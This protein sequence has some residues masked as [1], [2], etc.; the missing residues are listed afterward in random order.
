MGLTQQRIE[1]TS[2]PAVVFSLLGAV[3]FVRVV[4][5]GSVL[6]PAEDATLLHA[7]EVFGES[8][9]KRIAEFLPGRT[10]VQCRHRLAVLLGQKEEGSSKRRSGK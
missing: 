9:W 6:S 7:S 10:D 2:V 4:V 8:S 5:L 3:S 1:I